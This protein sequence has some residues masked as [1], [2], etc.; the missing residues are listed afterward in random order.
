[1][2]RLSCSVPNPCTPVGFWS[3]AK[4]INEVK[5]KHQP[6]QRLSFRRANYFK[7]KS[8]HPDEDAALTCKSALVRKTHTQ[9]NP[10]LRPRFW[11][12]W[13]GNWGGWN[14]QHSEPER[15]R[16]SGHTAT[17]WGERSSWF[18]APQW[19]C[20]SGHDGA[21]SPQTGSEILQETEKTGGL[22]ICSRLHV[23]NQ[24]CN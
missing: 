3:G 24:L 13:R 18:Q 5:I 21:A 2:T 8:R 1:M 10:Y 20:A 6:M 4:K 23:K 14:P 22:F 9:L 12:F 17:V 15:G 11:T 16:C 7:L 19:G